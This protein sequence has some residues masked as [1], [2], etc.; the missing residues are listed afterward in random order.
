[1]TA[2]GR[3]ATK[4]NTHTDIFLKI[5]LLQPLSQLIYFARTFGSHD[6]VCEN[7]YLLGRDT[8]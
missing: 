6:V 2:L 8:A 7:C 4:K 5:L 1:M 3:S